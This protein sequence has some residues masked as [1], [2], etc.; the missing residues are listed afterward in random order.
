PD[1]A[2]EE[3]SVLVA[4]N[5]LD[6]IGSQE[7]PTHNLANVLGWCVLRFSDL[8]P[9]DHRSTW[10]QPIEPYGKTADQLAMDKQ[11]HAK[12][13]W[14]LLTR[15]ELG[16]VMPEV[17][18]IT[19]QG[20]TDRRAESIALGISDTVALKR[21][22]SI[23]RLG[24]ESFKSKKEDQAPNQHVYQTIKSARHLVIG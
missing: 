19:D 2:V 8:D 22:D 21:E 12:K 16:T 9:A 23:S 5:D 7:L 20:G 17:V 24:D 11:E 13:I 4:I 14:S 6:P 3:P 10:D 1:L 18:V 15:F